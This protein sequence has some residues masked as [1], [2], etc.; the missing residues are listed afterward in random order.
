MTLNEKV[1]VVTGGASGI[2]R[3]AAI[4]CGKNGANV[5]VVDLDKDGLG[6]CVEEIT[7]A[8]GS[9]EGH[10]IDVREDDQVSLL[11]SALGEQ[12]GRVDGLIHAAGVLEGALVPIDE[13]EELTWDKVLDINL[14]GSFLMSKHAVPLIEKSERGVIL[15]IASGAGVRGGSSSVAY[16]SSKGGVHGLSLV[17]AAQLADRK[18]RVHGVCP[19]SLATPLKLRQVEKSAKASGG[20]FEK[21]AAALGDPMGVG[22]VL[23]FLVSDDAD[24]VRGSVFTR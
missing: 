20:D 22:K 13:F 1:I 7:G 6:T 16:G 24:Y 9:A 2:G 10:C 19:G 5:V 15:L 21:M 14:K 4:C 8:G 3:A 23:A 12:H 11:F 18:I 17:L